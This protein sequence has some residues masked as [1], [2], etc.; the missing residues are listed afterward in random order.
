[1][2]KIIIPDQ[3][4]FLYFL[5][6]DQLDLPQLLD[7]VEVEVLFALAVME[8]LVRFQW[9]HPVPELRRRAKE[10]IKRV[11]KWLEGQQLIGPGVKAGFIGSRPDSE[12]MSKNQFN[13]QRQEDILLGT[14]LEYQQTRLDEMVILLTGD[15]SFASR[16]RLLGIKALLLSGDHFLAEAEDN[17]QAGNRKLRQ[18]LT[19]FLYRTSS[20]SL[21]IAGGKDEAT[22]AIAPQLDSLTATMQAQLVAVA[23][24]M[25]RE[26]N[27]YQAEID[28]DELVDQV[29]QSFPVSGR[30]FLDKGTV[31]EVDRYLREVKDYPDKF[32]HYLHRC[33]EIINQHRRTIRLDLEVRNEGGASAEEVL[34]VL[35]LPEQLEWYWWPGQSHMPAPPA[36]PT[37]PAPGPPAMEKGFHIGGVSSVSSRILNQDYI[38]N[39]QR[40][41]ALPEISEA[42][43]QLKWELG[44]YR[45]HQTRLLGPLYVRFRHADDI[46]DFAIA[47][48]IQDKD[49]PDAVKGQLLLLLENP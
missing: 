7:C 43:I 22:L 49:N 19:G 8:E 48:E 23:E 33:L 20:L 3:S 32:E 9:D 26:T 34:L 10:A 13:W 5:P 38:S 21:Y 29:M 14:I 11:E 17:A 30:S 27:R 44:T 4:V 47:W 18:E 42:G 6:L 37:P 36:P 45:H 25:R 46:S 28:L 12:T 16:G 24:N 15:K 40:A 31:D 1:M 41:G 35:T 2:R 39:E